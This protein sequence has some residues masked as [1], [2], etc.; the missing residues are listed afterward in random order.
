MCHF[1]LILLTSLINMFYLLCLSVLTVVH[2]YCGIYISYCLMLI[3]V[4]FTS[5]AL[6]C[7]LFKLCSLLAMTIWDY[8]YCCC[9]L[10]AFLKNDVLH[11]VLTAVRQSGKSSKVYVHVCIN[12]L[13]LYYLKYWMLIMFWRSYCQLYKFIWLAICVETVSSVLYYAFVLLV[14]PY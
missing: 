1:L 14:D 5:F 8:I 4:Y 13:I 2:L 12:T 10:Y 3:E 7:L 11:Q 9:M 6:Y